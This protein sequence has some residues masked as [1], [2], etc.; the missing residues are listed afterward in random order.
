M[1][2]D[3]PRRFRL[4]AWGDFEGGGIWTFVPD[5]PFTDI[6]YDWRIRADKPLLRDLSF[7]FR[8]LFSAN[9]RWA[10]ARGEESLRRELALRGKAHDTGLPHQE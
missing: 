3:Y 4:E 6:T 5:G 7:L 9:H 2:R 1:L 8:P 10:T